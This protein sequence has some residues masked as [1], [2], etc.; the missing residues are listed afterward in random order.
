MWLSKWK[1]GVLAVE[2][3]VL[4]VYWKCGS[5]SGSFGVVA[6]CGDWLFGSLGAAVIAIII[7]HG[8]SGYAAIY[9][10]VLT[11]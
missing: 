11:S 9:M 1:I 5:Q 2:M 3:C 6:A 8:P 7:I 10:M 4:V